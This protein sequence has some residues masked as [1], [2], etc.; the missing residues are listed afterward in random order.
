VTDYDAQVLLLGP[1]GYWKFDEASGL[2]LA[3][4]SGHGH[5]LIAGA[6]AIQ[7]YRIPGP[8]QADIPYGLHLINTGELTCATNTVGSYGI[9]SSFSV[10]VWMGAVKP[11]PAIIPLVSKGDAGT[12]VTPWWTLSLGANGVPKFWFR[13]VALADFTLAGYGDLTDSSYT[14]RGPFHHVVGTYTPGTATL[15]VDG[16]QQATLAVP[17]TGW[18]TGAQGLTV[19]N[20]GGNRAGAWLAALALYPGQLSAAQVLS[21][22]NLGITGN[23]F[24]VG[25]L[26]SQLVVVTADLDAILKAVRRNIP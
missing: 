12:V 23:A 6:T 20:F 15:F 22:Y 1:D 10:E 2:T 24:T 14:N 13:N 9:G 26:Q 21:N 4:S 18:G 16:L 11:V 7:F 25:Q 5:P 8:S 17:N 19:N 3:D